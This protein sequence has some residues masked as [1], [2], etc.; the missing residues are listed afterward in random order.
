MTKETQKKQNKQNKQ[1]TYKNKVKTEFTPKF[2]K[3]KKILYDKDGF[4]YV[5]VAK[6]DNIVTK[7]FLPE[8]YEYTLYNN[9]K[10]TKT[11]EIPFNRK[12]A[13][14]IGTISLDH[15][16]PILQDLPEEMPDEPDTESMDIPEYSFPLK[17]KIT[18]PQEFTDENGQTRI[19]QEMPEGRD[20]QAEMIMGKNPRDIW[21]RQLNATYNIKRPLFIKKTEQIASDRVERTKNRS[22]NPTN[23][24]LDPNLMECVENFIRKY[25]NKENIELED[26]PISFVSSTYKGSGQS[27][28]HSIANIVCGQKHWSIGGYNISSAT[29]NDESKE[30]QKWFKNLHPKFVSTVCQYLSDLF[31]I[32]PDIVDLEFRAFINSVRAFGVIKKSDNTLVLDATLFQNIYNFLYEAY[33][34]VQRNYNTDFPTTPTQTNTNDNKTIQAFY[35]N[36]KYCYTS[37]I[38][39][40]LPNYICGDE[41]T[42]NCIS[43]AHKILEVD[44]PAKFLPTTLS[45]YA[46]EK[47]KASMTDCTIIL[48]KIFNLIFS[49]TNHNTTDQI[50]QLLSSCNFFKSESDGQQSALIYGPFRTDEDEKPTNENKNKNPKSTGWFSGGQKKRTKKRVNRR[51]N[52]RVH[53]RGNKRTKKRV[54]R[55]CNKRTKKRVNR[56]GNKRTN[57]RT[58]KR[59]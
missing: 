15:S 22:G 56:R 3:G 58:K 55:R 41:E 19:L 53:R 57:R 33:D 31:V 10:I 54:N 47:F 32:S 23:F 34:I 52:K 26:I 1:K 27:T 43:F 44:N 6:K 37:S 12:E 11:D 35:K 50:K 2:F 14:D 9:S 38:S 21:W 45:D 8:E 16:D 7:Q 40:R 59:F 30:R 28:F 48:I 29:F 17:H 46:G 25:N 5:I 24:I 13:V 51:G 36:K 20:E 4:P 42:Y 49:N 39:D 18:G